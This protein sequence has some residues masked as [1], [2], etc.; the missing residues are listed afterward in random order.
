MVM[1]AAKGEESLGFDGLMPPDGTRSGSMLAENPRQG[2][3]AWN[4]PSRQGRPD[5]KPRTAIGLRA[6]VAP[7]SRQ[8]HCF[9]QRDPIGIRGGLNVYGYVGSSPVTYVDPGGLRTDM[10]WDKPPGGYPKPRSPRPF[11][12]KTSYSGEDLRRM[13]DNE[14]SLQAVCTAG[15]LLI[16]GWEAAATRSIIGLALDAAGWLGWGWTYL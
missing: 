5:A 10:G 8:V 16:G 7:E 1:L 15:L 9:L 2:L 4:R 12:G 14:T 6:S 13:I 3:R 11:R